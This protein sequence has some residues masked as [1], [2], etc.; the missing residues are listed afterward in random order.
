[1]RA[2]CAGLLLGLAVWGS[3]PALGHAQSSDTGVL[4]FFTGKI[5]PPRADALERQIDDAV[6]R[7]RDAGGMRGPV[8]QALLQ[9]NDT[10]AAHRQQARQLLDQ[11]TALVRDVRYDQALSALS[12]AE[13]AAEQGLAMLAEPQLLGDIFFQQGIALLASDPTAAETIWVQSFLFDPHRVIAQDAYPPKILDRLQAAA[14]KAETLPPRRP[15]P[16]QLALVGKLLG[17]KTLWLCQVWRQQDKEGVFVDRWDLVG[18]KK[19]WSQTVTWAASDPTE[20][21]ER[22]VDQALP[23][24]AS[25]IDTEPMVETSQHKPWVVWST[26]G[27]GGAALLTGALFAVVV[28]QKQSDAEGLAHQEPAVDYQSDVRSIEDSAWR[29][30]TGA[31]AML[32]AG[33]TAALGAAAMELWL[34]QD[35]QTNQWLRW[36]TTGLSAAGLVSGLAFALAAGGKQGEA[37]DL[38][39]KGT[40]VDYE[41]RIVDLEDARRWHQRAAAISL[42]V[43]GTAAAVALA[44]WL[45][46]DQGHVE[47]SADSTQ[48][49]RWQL[50]PTGVGLRLGF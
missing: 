35:P 2:R 24:P 16:E 26:A 18:R 21:A 36:S 19:E 1:M 38:A 37:D 20:K 46:P 12:A 27:V 6:A 8:V 30:E 50:S 7:H 17:I 13:D 10:L 22:R 9:Q 5:P 3:G 39:G 15:R 28:S 47:E 41:P 29:Y 45:W 40:L 43:G 11:A 31:A 48:G 25:V 44:C 34:D 14:Q 32:A 23:G 33:G 4:I 42:A 49:L